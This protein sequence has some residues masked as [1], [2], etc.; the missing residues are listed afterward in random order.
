MKRVLIVVLLNQAVFW[1]L[2]LFVSKN[3]WFTI[4]IYAGIGVS[5]GGIFPICTTYSTDF[6][7]NKHKTI[8]TTILMLLDSNVMIF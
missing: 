7:A 6:V 2:L 1:S 8:V 3:I 5:A 4:G